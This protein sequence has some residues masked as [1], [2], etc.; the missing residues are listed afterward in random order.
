MYLSQ[1]KAMAGA[2]SIYVVSVQSSTWQLVVIDFVTIIIYN[3]YYW[4]IPSI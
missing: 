3:N 1:P 4:S 2:R